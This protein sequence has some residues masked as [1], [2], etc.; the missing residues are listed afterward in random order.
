M[1]EVMNTVVSPLVIKALTDA[2]TGGGAYDGKPPIGV[3]RSAG[4]LADFF[5]ECGVD[6]EVSGSRVPAVREKLRELQAIDPSGRDIAKIIEHVSDP[7][8]N[9]GEPEKGEA[10]VDHLN[11]ALQADGL[12]VAILSGKAI[13]RRRGAGG[14]VVNAFAE[15]SATL[16]FDTVSR[17]IE[18][19][20][21][22]A[23]NDPEDA[24]TAACATLE[25]VCRSI[26][27]ELELPVPD[28]K[29]ISSLVRAVQDPLDLSPGRSDLPDEIADDI[30]QILGGL[31][32]TAKGIGA[33]RTHGGDAHGR[34]RG[35]RSVDARIAR[36]AINA[37]STVALFFIETW[38]RKQ[39]RA[40]PNR[41][42]RA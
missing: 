18:R 33:L 17:D 10:V 2:V 32:T 14:A 8:Q 13:L 16:D 28:K 9:L 41:D 23:D 25:A 12:K 7:R 1:I 40:L 27:A 39:K 35:R 34:E 19:A 15:K 37:A 36:L 22:N 20:T 11:R 3:Y 26:L 31:T 42:D 21:R 29:D 5:M 30:R 6:F 38:E 4:A 24:V